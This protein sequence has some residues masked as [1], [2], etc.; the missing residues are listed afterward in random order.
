MSQVQKIELAEMIADLR[1]E[2]LKARGQGAESELRFEIADLELEVQIAVT[3]GAKGG[4]GVKFWVY[5]AD[6]E[7]N[8][9]EAKTHKLKIRLKPL[10]ATDRSPF[11]VGDQDTLGG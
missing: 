3:K 5:N 11:D 1:V 4:G 8:A 6:A 10:N 7:V 2:L 9:S